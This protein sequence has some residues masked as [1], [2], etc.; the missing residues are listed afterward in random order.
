M[1]FSMQKV[2]C[3]P[4]ELSA[5]AALYTLRERQNQGRVDQPLTNDCVRIVA[6]ASLSQQQDDIF[7]AHFLLIYQIFII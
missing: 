6:D 4:G 2:L 5:L 1:C 3:R 7:Q